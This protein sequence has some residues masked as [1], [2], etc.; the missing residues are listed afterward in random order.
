[1]PKE[2]DL[3]AKSIGKAAKAAQWTKSS[4][5]SYSHRLRRIAALF[6]ALRKLRNRL[7]TVEP[8]KLDDESWELID[9][10]SRRLPRSELPKSF[11]WLRD[12]RV[13]QGIVARL[14]GSPSYKRGSISALKMAAELFL[15]DRILASK[16]SARNLKQ[17]QALPAKP[18]QI[19]IGGF[20]DQPDSLG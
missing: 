16:Y 9:D 1:M 11:A 17:E 14:G 20:A 5:D 19:A 4:A 2:P 10:I 18:S 12:R 8:D 3:I 15:G 13:V 7:D 6:C